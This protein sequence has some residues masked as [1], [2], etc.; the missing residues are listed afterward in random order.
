MGVKFVDISMDIF[1]EVFL[2]LGFFKLSFN[3]ATFPQV[4][5]LS[6]DCW[7]LKM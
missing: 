2:E 6:S 7:M 4:N 1:A 3:E 5:C